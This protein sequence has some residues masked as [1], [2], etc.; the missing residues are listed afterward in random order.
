[1]PET[2]QANTSRERFQDL[3]PPVL[4]KV[5]GRP[6]DIAHQQQAICE[7]I[8]M[9]KRGESFA[10]F[11]LNMDVLVKLRHL[12]NFRRAFRGLDSSRRTERR[13]LVSPP[14]RTCEF[15]RP[16]G[17]I[18]SFRW[19]T[20]PLKVIFPSIS[21]ALAAAPSGAWPRS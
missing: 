10:V 6:I 15:A 19:P 7:I 20:L 8:A 3:A 4:A 12:S 5:D 14:S 21:S 9:A 16:Q 18:S 13:S 1:M 2:F 11:P 17:Q